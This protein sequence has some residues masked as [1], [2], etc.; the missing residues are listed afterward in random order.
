MNEKPSVEVE[1]GP[2]AGPLTISTAVVAAAQE[3]RQQILEFAAA[4]DR[5]GCHEGSGIDRRQRQRGTERCRFSE[6][7]DCRQSD[8][9]GRAQIFQL[10]EILVFNF[11]IF[12]VFD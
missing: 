4:H 11:S 2:A 1:R 6:R 9:G 10:M 3:A 8:D 12:V 7:H 5:H